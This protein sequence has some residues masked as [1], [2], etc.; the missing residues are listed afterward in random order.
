MEEA[1]D[2]IYFLI[3]EVA[4]QETKQWNTQLAKELLEQFNF[5]VGEVNELQTELYEE[6]NGYDY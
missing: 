6:R 5:F 4:S 1:K 3:S 2:R